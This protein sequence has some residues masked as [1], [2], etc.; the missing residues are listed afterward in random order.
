MPVFQKDGD[1][2]G[3]RPVL[4]TM[5]GSDRPP[6]DIS[7]Y[8]RNHGPMQSN[9]LSWASEING[10]MKDRTDLYLYTHVINHT[11]TSWPHS[12]NSNIRRM[13]PV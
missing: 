5:K 2:D 7:D 1:E 11:E 12:T 10:R 8:K 6:I 9:K 3:A 4:T 13:F